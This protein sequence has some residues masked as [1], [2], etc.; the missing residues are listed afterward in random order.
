MPRVN[1]L[2]LS[3]IRLDDKNKIIGDKTFHLYGE[4]S[5]FLLENGGGKSS[6]I[7]Y[8]HQ[9]I[10]PNHEMGKRKMVEMVP[11]DGTIH[12]AAEWLPDE[13][14]RSSF[15]T[16]FCFQNTGK[17]SK[18]SN[19]TYQYFNYI[20]EYE[21]EGAYRIED[22][23]FVVNGMVNNYDQLKEK[24]KRS[25]G[26]H[27]PPTNA[28]YQEEL[29]SYKILSTEWS[30]IS[31]VNSSE[32][33]VTDFFEK[34]DTTQRLLEKLLIPSVLE[35]LYPEE[36][37]RYS[38]K[39]SFKEYKDSLM[40]LPEM[41][42]N[43]RDYNIINEN[44][45]QIINVCREYNSFKKKLVES[46]TQLSRLYITL[47]KDSKANTIEL[48][49]IVS[50]LK[51][52]EETKEDLNW[53][54]QSYEVLLLK[55]KYKSSKEIAEKDEEM[56]EQIK[57]EIEQLKRKE[58]EQ[59]A[60]RAYGDYKTNKLKWDQ[61]SSELEAAQ[62]KEGER[63]N[64]LQSIRNDLSRRYYY[65]VRQDKRELKALTNEQ[66]DV[67]TNWK[68]DVNALK[69]NL[70][71][72]ET[73]G[74]RQAVLQNNVE[75]YE[76]ELL[77]LKKVLIVDWKENEEITHQHLTAKVNIA[78][79]EE[80]TYRR[81]TEQFDTDIRGL[82]SLLDRN[83]LNQE[84]NR[85]EHT[86]VEK[87]F[88]TF[89]DKEISLMENTYKY[90]TIRVKD[91]LFGDQESILWKLERFKHQYDEEIIQLSIEMD[92][93]NQIRKVIETKGY[94]IQNE[95]ERVKDYLVQK[96][97]DVVLGVEWIT[98]VIM[99]DSSKG[100]LLEKNPL[101][102]VSILVEDAQLVKVKRTL[103]H[104]KEELSIPIILVNKSCMDEEQKKE[105]T[106]QL[107]ASSYLF[108]HFKVRLKMED[109]ETYL[110]ELENKWNE[111]DEKR[112]EWKGKLFELNSFEHSLTDFWKLYTSYS[113]KE[114]SDKVKEIEQ[115]IQKL[116]EE[117]NELMKQK[118]DKHAAYVESKTRWEEKE[119]E[120][121]E[122]TEKTR[123]IADF[124][125]RYNNIY[126][127][128]GELAKLLT[129]LSQLEEQKKY[130]E[131]LV[132]GWKIKDE[133]IKE[134]IRQLKS[135]SAL[136]KKDVVD[137]QIRDIQ[138]EYPSTEEE[139]KKTLEKYKA[140]RIHNS[141]DAKYSEDLESTLQQYEE[142]VKRAILDIKQNGFSLELMD[143]LMLEFE[144]G[145]LEQIKWNLSELDNRLQEELE[146]KEQSTKAFIQA[147]TQYQ[148][149]FEL[150]G[151]NEMFPYGANPQ[152][153]LELFQSQLALAESDEKR[154]NER[155]EVLVKQENGNRN[156]IDDLET[157]KE[158][159]IG[160]L[161]LTV[162]D[163]GNWNRNKP[164]QDVRTIRNDIEDHKK[165]M[166]LS[167][168]QL[169]KKIEHLREEVRNTNNTQL[170]QLT[171]DFS[172]ILDSYIDDYEE[173][174]RTFVNLLEYV[175]KL[176]DSIH[177]RKK[178]LDQRSGELVEQM[179]DRAETVY[180]NIMEIA[181][182]SQVEE[183]GEITS[184]F[185]I[186]WPKK[187]IEECKHE[188]DRFIQRILEELVEMNDRNAKVEEMDSL[189]DKRVNMNDILNCYAETSRCNIKTLKH[190]NELLNKNDFY[191]WNQV[192]KWSGGEKHATQISLFITLI[193]HLRKKRYARENAW[194][195][196]ILDNPFGKA[197]SD[198]VVKPMVSLATKTNTQLFC[199]TGIKE[200]S[201]QRE[202][203]TVISN[204]YVEQRGRLLLNTREKHKD[205]SV[206][207][208]DSIFYVK[209]N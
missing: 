151:E 126:Q 34:A 178:E 185:K 28:R 112:V 10:L 120:R 101:L 166:G 12:V 96:G 95:L 131:S 85:K 129:Q 57:K 14:Y 90:L 121:I 154:L 110:V 59:Y 198:F 29:E 91:H 80:K 49:Q 117:K 199:F 192:A 187:S 190:R 72:T 123:K 78:L 3:N 177:L 174:I 15:I 92:N 147:E 153:E 140:F 180:K 181:K 111:C 195:F 77:S 75:T 74:K 52:L 18:A 194:K 44:A 24:L 172:K 161:S 61:K 88:E 193:N 25:K 159:L 205:P 54:I 76:K 186:Y 175:E 36:Q 157:T 133:E 208:L 97:I 86:T 189:F 47:L 40:E 170:M 35:S 196:I 127:N 100:E 209:G 99:D 66:K 130:Y 62:L 79:E 89:A 9:L 145:I 50:Y 84:T 103:D 55:N 4:N 58:K 30:N 64:E 122:L 152:T 139:Y 69:D 132:E 141:S 114:L 102:P 125:Q 148:T 109:W 137:Y 32:G 136:L 188:L 162:L 165:E 63:Q 155:N 108:H 107:G 160:S 22:L 163:E 164:I 81:E 87:E 27:F 16:G 26:V 20:I 135:H 168:T 39:E 206:A 150:L 48:E 184:L 68:L 167:R 23:P 124:I 56:V 83:G 67:L 171:L 38:F 113:R 31:L 201:I 115:A 203:K 8:I 156:A 19:Q 149:Q 11:V 71:E 60:A 119:K 93:I 128:K 179:Y 7:Q 73:K 6:I 5:L 98:K 43:L 176:E 138:E 21:Y 142:L 94:H 207:E 42:K 41:K 169:L 173:I 191:T 182:S 134:K 65:L 17:K 37:E 106:F 51:R 158:I 105:S 33:G 143:K 144:S 204:Q 183:K 200:K 46:Q 13:D 146:I 45:D 2:R 104:Y 1:K 116:I 197:S 202:F 70:K 82:E 118:E 53:K